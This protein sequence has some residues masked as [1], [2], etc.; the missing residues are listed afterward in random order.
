ML[1]SL[2]LLSIVRRSRCCC[3]LSV[4]SHD[5][6][7]MTYAK[8]S[9]R[10]IITATSVWAPIESDLLLH[11]W[12]NNNNAM[13]L[14]WQYFHIL[15]RDLFAFWSCHSD[16]DLLKPSQSVVIG[17]TDSLA[18]KERSAKNNRSHQHLS[19]DLGHTTDDTTKLNSLTT[20]N[21]LLMT[22]PEIREMSW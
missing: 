8:R 20:P 7:L 17:Q 10:K 1:Y 3:C 18:K 19:G 15:I 14:N 6:W 5:L 22:L 16:L 13:Q 2:R 21:T 11:Q 9:N 4:I 12:H